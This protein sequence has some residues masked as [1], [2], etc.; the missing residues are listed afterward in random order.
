MFWFACHVAVIKCKGNSK[1]SE[2]KLSM[3]I[4]LDETLVWRRTFTYSYGTWR[5]MKK[6]QLNTGAMRDG[7][8]ITSASE[9]DVFVIVGLNELAC[10]AWRFES[11]FLPWDAFKALSKIPSKIHHGAQTFCMQRKLKMMNVIAIVG[12]IHIYIKLMRP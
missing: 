2:N 5:A 12:T 7:I 11:F 8:G 6:T 3:R 9:L 10:G 1:Q 4:C